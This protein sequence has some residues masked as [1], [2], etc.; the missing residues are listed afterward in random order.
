M[1]T[2]FAT[3]AAKYPDQYFDKYIQSHIIMFHSL[4][5]KDHLTQRKISLTKDMV[6]ISIKVY[7][8]MLAHPSHKW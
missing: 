7:H 3:K 2:E 6:I 4:P 8:T 1:G 5:K